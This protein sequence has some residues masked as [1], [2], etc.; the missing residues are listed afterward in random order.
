RRAD[1]EATL[2]PGWAHG[3]E[4]RLTVE[5]R[6]ITLREGEGRSVWFAA[7]APG[8]RFFH[9]RERLTLVC[10]GPGSYRVVSLD[11][12]ETMVFAAARPGGPCLLRRIEDAHGNALRLDYE[13]ETLAQIVDT[14]GRVVA[15]RWAGGRLVR[16]EVRAGRALQQ[17]VDY[18]YDAQGRLRAAVDALGHADR[19]AYDG[20]GRMTTAVVKNGTRFTYT[21]DPT[22]GRCVRTGGPGGLYEVA[23]RH[24]AA[25][26]AVGTE[27]ASPTVVTESAEPRIY[28]GN[29]LGLMTRASLP[30]GTLLEEV[31][32]DDDGYLI[33]EANGAGEGTQYWYDE[34]GN[35]TRI[36]DA[37]R[38]E[39]RFDYADDRLVR[40][41]DPE[42]VVT[43][44]AYDATGN[45]VGARSSHGRW[46][47][48][49]YDAFGRLVRV[50]DDA[51][52]ARAFAYDAQ[53]NLVAE[54]DAAGATT[55][56]AYDALGRPVAR[57]DALGR[58]TRV[59]YDRLGQRT[60]LR[61]PDG[62]LW[63]WAYDPMGKVAR[64]T[65]PAGR[66]T[67]FEN[68]GMGVPVRMT[69]P[70]GQA[71]AF[72]YTPLERLASVTNPRGETY[73][74]A[75][76][77]AGRVV[78]ETTFDGRTL[79]YHYSPAGRVERLDY[80]DRTTR[81]FAYDRLGHVTGDATGDGTVTLRR[82]R[83]GRLVEALLD[84]GGER[85]ST[86]FERDER[87][88]VVAEHQGDAV[89]RYGYDAAGRLVERVLPGGL[90]TRYAFDARDALTEVEHAGF[91]LR[92]ERDEVGREVRRGTDA[93]GIESRY[94]A[95]D[96]L[97]EQEVR[98][99]APGGGLPAAVVR[100]RWHYDGSGLVTQL[101]DA[102]WG[103]TFYR[104]GRAGEL[105]EARRGALREV[106]AYDD[107][108][109]LRALTSRLG[110]SAPSN[111]AP[112]FAWGTAD[113]DAQAWERAP[114]N[115]LRSTMTARYRYDA[116]ARRIG[117]RAFDGDG[118][119]P[120]GGE[121]LYVWDE[122][123]RLRDVRLPDGRR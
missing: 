107:A 4:A 3:F 6:L 9:R 108:G 109:S 59:T 12:R 31:A 77:D 66:T 69:T 102:R 111:G 91:A 68:A 84:E 57:T 106:F 86:R 5:G 50:D 113:G 41:V 72:A 18:Q 92:F 19:Y 45:L 2:G 61:T 47:A 22:S 85:T 44:Y 7:L 63:Q 103:S 28:R 79:A 55:R 35:R 56:Y 30:D 36:V 10:D 8:E 38:N 46:L 110:D 1:R 82:D 105:L 16:L 39:T 73:A 123:D 37:N 75:Y 58:V 64:E 60:S 76:D 114:G 65:D 98:V 48:L 88:R 26:P 119:G 53:H 62:A 118:A 116:R 15:V 104:Y 89:V 117:K 67:R 25:S 34:R 54:T 71:W 24:E 11:T 115:L 40:R 27:S 14:A 97:L 21:Y 43:D 122:R 94:D 96:R 83:R 78:R 20:K 112:S 33:A 81:A 52:R 74:F 87:G 49:A 29:A 17:W 93:Y 51:G 32:Y 80:P 23:F 90:R 13:G 121:T 95:A 101:D 70:D 120:E 100:R 42:G 99:P